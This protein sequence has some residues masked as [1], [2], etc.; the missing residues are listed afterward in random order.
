MFALADCNNFFASC[1]RVFRP[2]LQGKPVIVLS[3]NDGCAVARSNEAKA[4]GIKM[5]DPYFKIRNIVEKNGVQVFSGNFPLY[6]DMSRRVQE[7]LRRFSPSVEQYSIDEAFLDF[8]GIQADFDALAKRISAE[9]LRCTGIPVSVGVAPT[10]TLAKVASKL[11]KQYPKLRGGCYM[12]RPQDVEKVLRRF[13]VADVWGIGRRSVPKLEAMGIK[14]AWDY[15]QLQENV[16][17]KLFALPGFRTWQELR[18]IPC[19]EFE[20][21]VEAK[22]T[23]CVSR[24]FAHEIT[25][26]Q[27]LC[28]QTAN[29]A[30][31]A[32]QKLRAQHSLCLEMAVFAF[33]N[34]F[35]DNVPQTHGSS[36]VTFPDGT[37]D[38]KAFVGA[39]VAATRELFRPGYGYKKAGVVILKLIQEEDAT[40]SLFADTAAAERSSRLSAALDSVNSAFGPGSVRFAVQ[41]DGKVFS[42]RDHQSPHYTTLWSDIP[43]VTVK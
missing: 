18:G 9:C 13:P 26:V 27:E 28:S 40:G 35:K 37:S 42:A 19:I 39:A 29:F 10:K 32:V 25:N 12:W 33:T 11:C 21:Y 31:S 34:R 43:K 36:L 2:D 38:H 3:N 5:G 23:I 1:E 4:L 14:T 7:V 30:L 17:R 20:D 6:G 16:V 8:R 41:G 15:T 22:Q 24:S